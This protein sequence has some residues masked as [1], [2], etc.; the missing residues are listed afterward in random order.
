[1]RC[2]AGSDP[3]QLKDARRVVIK[4]RKAFRDLNHH[5]YAPRATYE[6]ALIYL[7]L[8][9]RDRCTDDLFRQYLARA[10]KE[11]DEVLRVSRESKDARWI[12]NALVIESRIERKLGNFQEAIKL[13]T[14]A[15]RAGI[16]QTLCKIDALI[17]HAESNISWVKSEV[18]RGAAGST[19]GKHRIRLKRARKALAEALKLNIRF[20]LA[21]S[22]ESQNEKI[23]SVCRLLIA[24]ICVLENDQEQAKASF[25]RWKE[26]GGIEHQN[27]RELAVSVKSEIDALTKVFHI[28]PE[29]DE[30]V[31]DVLNRNLK[32]FL[33][34]TAKR[35]YP[36]NQTK[37][38]KLL[39]INRQ[40]LRNWE[41]KL[42]EP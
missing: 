31:Y 21:R 12:S 1:M 13:S 3:K 22:P 23:E 28:N 11:A 27:I 39:K 25:Q 18:E 30:L 32:T 34:E 19:A 26:L 33:I 10:R 17:A 42:R 38:A 15:R 14:D 41:T 40:T 29:S 5:R 8:A 7:A 20:T 2:Q 6:L 36:S 16:K 9:D 35:K 37:Q 4:A 24:R